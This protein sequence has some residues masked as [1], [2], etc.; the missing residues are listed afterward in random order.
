MTWEIFKRQDLGKWICISEWQWHPGNFDVCTPESAF[1][2]LIDLL[3]EKSISKH[4]SS[5]E[6]IALELLH[7]CVTMEQA[8]D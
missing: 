1:C 2:A 5:A 8:D 7:V 3:V 6:V 4:P